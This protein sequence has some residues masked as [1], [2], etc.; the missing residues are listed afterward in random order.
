MTK[1]S[2]RKSSGGELSPA[3]LAIAFVAG[4]LAVLVFH[5]ILLL[6]FYLPG[7]IPV[8]PFSMMPTA[9][10]TVPEVI[11]SSFW[12]GVW[13]IVFVLMLPRFFRGTSYWLASA[14]TGGVALTVVYMFVVVPLK[15]GA[16]PPEM[17]GLFIVGFLLNAAWGIGWALF[18]RLFDRMRGH[19]TEA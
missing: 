17:V 8:A 12:G 9:P 11:S 10:F 14:I 5:Q 3:T 19:A 2:T 1:I 6:V 18:L 13:G 16:M 7:V 15:T 4:V